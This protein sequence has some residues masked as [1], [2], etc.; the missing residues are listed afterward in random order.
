[1]ASRTES[2]KNKPG[3]YRYHSRDCARVERGT[4]C[5]CSPGYQASVFSNRDGKRIRKHFDRLAEAE[6]WRSDVLSAMRSGKSVTPNAKTVAVALDELIAGMRSDAILN[7]SGR[8]Y[9]PSAKRS[10]ERVAGRL[11]DELGNLRLSDLRRSHVNAMIQRQRSAGMSASSIRNTLDPLRVVFRLA[12]D[13]EIVSV[14]P[15][16]KLRLPSVKAEATERKTVSPATAATMI[17]ALS[18]EDQA[19]WAMA[20]YVGLRRGEL[21]ELRWS[22]ID[23]PRR[24]GR[25]ERAWDDEGGAVIDTKSQAG[26]RMFPLVEPVRARLLDHKMRTG[27]RDDDL[28]FGR[29][30][31]DRFVP[32]TIRRRALKAWEAAGLESI[33][34]HEG[35]H[36]AATAGSTSGLDDLALAH[37]MGHSS[38]TITKD[39]YG[40]IREDQIAGVVDQL[41]RYYAASA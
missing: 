40:H 7:R 27:R 13:D 2:L 26:R 14:D 28:V 32:S 19:L 37:I 5:N 34:L 18:I 17:D 6:G 16:H 11:K 41:D 30:S 36:S 10:Y 23:L 1:M 20:I 33:T 21:Q 4:K 39:L 3:V 15:T 35:R 31:E 9:K 22:D 25:C 24:M 8:P 29:S 12:L 38:V